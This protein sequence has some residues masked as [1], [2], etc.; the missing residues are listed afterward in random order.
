MGAEWRRNKQRI[1]FKPLRNFA[2]PIP[3]T[4]VQ[5]FGGS[6]ARQTHG[7]C[8]VSRLRNDNRLATCAIH[9]VR[10]HFSLAKLPRKPLTYRKDKQARANSG[11]SFQPGGIHEQA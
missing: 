9:H 5:D 1:R 2:S 11:R 4:K 6:L 8:A 3:A 7:E 10:M